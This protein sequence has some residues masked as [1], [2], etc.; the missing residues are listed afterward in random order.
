MSK[1]QPAVEDTPAPAVTGGKRLEREPLDVETLQGVLAG[2][3]QSKK[4]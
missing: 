1:Q 3:E 4:R 2:L